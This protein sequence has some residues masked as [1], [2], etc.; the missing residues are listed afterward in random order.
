MCE[1]ILSFGQRGGHFF[2][3]PSRREAMRLPKK[4][5]SLLSSRQ[6]QYVHHVALGFEDSFLITWR[7]NNG[8]NRIDSDGLPL[9]LREFLYARDPQRGFE[10]DFSRIQCSIGPYNASFFVHD[11]SAYRWLNLPP[12]LLLALQSRINDGNW[13]DR[14]RLVA[15]GANDNFVLITDKHAPV[16]T[17]NNYDSLSNLLD[18]LALQNRGIADIHSITLHAHRFGSFITQSRNGTLSHENLPS[19]SIPALQ[20]MVAPILKDSKEA[21]RRPLARRE[22]DLRDTLQRR[23]SNLQQRAQLRREWTDSKQQFTAQAKGI[24]LSLSINL[25]AGGLARLL[26]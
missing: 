3:C 24:K 18:S 5:A 25:S 4:L 23:S 17:L 12:K 22:S 15:L 13:T 11:G 2:Q 6:L 14:P 1:S 21:E 26:G 7:D 9:E 19:H 8:H 20:E 16:W 10:R